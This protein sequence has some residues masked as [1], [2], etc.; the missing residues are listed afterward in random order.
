[1]RSALVITLAKL[2]DD[3]FYALKSDT[4]NISC[5][6]GAL[7][8]CRTYDDEGLCCCCWVFLLLSI[9]GIDV[10]VKSAECV[11]ERCAGASRRLR[12]VCAR[13]SAVWRWLHSAA[14]CRVPYRGRKM[15][16]TSLERSRCPDSRGRT[17]TLLCLC[18]LTTKGDT[19]TKEARGGCD[20]GDW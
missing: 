5:V 9:C 16:R 3:H 11:C 7:S 2:Y 18:L 1:M 12:Y 6:E 4:K 14:A 19:T 20:L 10:N 17:K 8:G 13:Q 15:R